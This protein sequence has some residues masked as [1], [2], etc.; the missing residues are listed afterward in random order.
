MKVNWIRDLIFSDP[1]NRILGVNS[2]NEEYLIRYLYVPFHII[3]TGN[4]PYRRLRI[5]SGPRDGKVLPKS[6]L[7]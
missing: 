5:K 1:D 3:L 6:K 2:F 4:L 7:R